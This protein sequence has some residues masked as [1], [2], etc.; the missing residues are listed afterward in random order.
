MKPGKLDSP[1]LFLKLKVADS[2]VVKA[3]LCNERM[4]SDNY[5]YTDFPL[6]RRQQP[7]GI[8]LKCH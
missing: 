4:I 6:W 2:V 7:I 1:E 3:F 5:P 8:E